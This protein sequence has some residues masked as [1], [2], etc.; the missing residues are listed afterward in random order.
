[1][2]LKTAVLLGLC[3]ALSL[4][5]CQLGVPE[6]GPTPTV[7]IAVT[8]TPETLPTASPTVVTAMPTLPLVPQLESPTP[9]YTPGPPTET[10]TP[11]PTPGPFEYVIQQN[12]TLIY[13]LRQ[14][15]YTELN[16]INDVLALNPLLTSPDRLPPPGSTILIPRP[17]PTVTPEG[18]DLTLAVLPP[19]M[20]VASV[21]ENAEIIQ[22]PIRE[23]ETILG[24]AAQNSTTLVVLATLNPQL[25]FFG[26]DFRNPSGGPDCNVS[27]QVGELVN[28]PALTPTPTLSPTFSGRETATP[29]PTYPPP[30]MVFPPHERQRFCADFP[31]PV[32]QRWHSCAR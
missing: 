5:A 9:T 13:I 32:G 6:G 1:M 22:V 10:F 3:A 4:A 21:S 18:Y 29:T 27:L 26:C 2:P 31:A 20:V 17:S 14:F 28:V 23:G 24:V 19:Q 11:S 15:G 7:G 30:A 12:D 8:D 16:V 25:G